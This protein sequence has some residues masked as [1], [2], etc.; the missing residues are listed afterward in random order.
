MVNNANMLMC[1]YENH[2]LGTFMHISVATNKLLQEGIEL[3]NEIYW[4]W[5]Y[6]PKLVIDIFLL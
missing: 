6:Y 2:A 1:L 4:I 3:S 5:T